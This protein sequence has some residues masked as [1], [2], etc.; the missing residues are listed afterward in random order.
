MPAAV[1]V[2]YDIPTWPLIEQI[3]IW[4]PDTPRWFHSRA[5]AGPAPPWRKPTLPV[6]ANGQIAAGPDRSM[7]S[8]RRVASSPSASSQVTTSKASSTGSPEPFGAT[9]R[10][11]SRIRLGS[12][13]IVNH[14]LTLRHSPPW[15]NGW[16]GLPRSRT[17]R[18][19][20]TVTIHEHPSGQSSG[21]DPR[22]VPS[23]GGG[24]CP[25]GRSAP[26]SDPLIGGLVVDGRSP[27]APLFGGR[28]S[29]A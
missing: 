23:L 5:P 13:A 10:S 19:S 16:S 11:G 24:G 15:V 27:A 7:M 2:V 6:P 26:A 28:S 1:P 8:L 29:A 3:E 12:A 21:Q 25:S 22:M 18:P 20:S 9:R 17:A 4:W 14:G